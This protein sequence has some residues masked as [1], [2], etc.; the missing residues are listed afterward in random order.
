MSKKTNYLA[1]ESLLLIGIA[2]SILFRIIWL[3]SREFWY[4]EALSILLS[5]G[6]K[7]AY[8]TPSDTPIVLANYTKL[9]QLPVEQGFTD[10][11]KTVANLL[12]G[13]SAEPHPPLFF[14][15]QHF[16]L[17]LFGN[18]ETAM[19]SVIALFS[20]GAIA[21][22]YGL[23][24][25]LLGYRG[26]LLFAA[27]LGLN[28]FYLFHALNVRMYGS[29]VF[30]TVLSA[31]S[32][33]ELINFR[34][35]NPETEQQQRK[36]PKRD[37]VLWTIILIGSVTAGLM[38]FYYFAI[39]LIGLG[40]LVLWLDR[41][42]WWYYGLSFLLSISLTIPWILWGTRQQL[43]NADLE[44]FTDSTGGISAIIRHLQELI[45]TLGIQLVIGDW[46]SS[47]PI[48]VTIV[49]GIA[50]IALLVWCSLSLV[51][52]NQYQGLGI[53]LL[54]GVFPLLVMVGLD[55]LGKKFTLG[56]GWSRSVIF[57]L[58]GCLFLI[59]TAIN[60]TV[61]KWQKPVAVT[62]LVLYLCINVADFSLRPRWM[63]HQMAEI[64][65]QDANA[66]TLIVMNSNAW[67]H[68]LRLAYY[69]PPTSPLMLLAQPAN[70]LAPSLEKTLTSPA[71]QYQRI[72]W[73]DSDRPLWGSKPVT[74]PQKQQIEE[75]LAAQFKR[76]KT[77]RLTGT[78]ALDNFTLN[79]YERHS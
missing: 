2:L 25:C 23:G 26:G 70:N 68:V 18:S 64:I 72:L 37:K 6:Q 35:S 69:L 7:L 15:E 53:A 20:I 36:H 65:K 73:L 11:L 10:I 56:F 5:N 43:R 78:W 77:E 51:R 38:T 74:E 66:P 34:D 17:R 59:V 76:E 30:W 29:L 1:L 41:R 58:P 42:R 55:I 27:L 8:Q 67:G 33:L 3:G 32:L 9:L 12:K 22:A 54:L 16:W 79:V 60:R 21:C 52:E 45:Q 48:W 19:R 63:F 28:P 49:A 39:Y 71:E 4:D 14:L 13:L 50:A 57:V 24:R 44:R 61:G 46:A 40:V 75:I 31:W 62:I 47:L